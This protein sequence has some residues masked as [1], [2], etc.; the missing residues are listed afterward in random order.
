MRTAVCLHVYALRSRSSHFS[1]ITRLFLALILILLETIFLS[2]L[3]ILLLS[4]LFLS[5][6]LLFL[7]NFGFPDDLP[8]RVQPQSQ[9]GRAGRHAAAELPAQR[10]KGIGLREPG[11]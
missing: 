3:L 11:Q 5:Y 7:S 9:A 2:L 8:L 6:F 4:L 1:I 10:L